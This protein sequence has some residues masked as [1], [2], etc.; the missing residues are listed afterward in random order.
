MADC[1]ID[2][3]VAVAVLAPSQATRALNAFAASPPARLIAPAAFGFE[4]RNAVVRLERRGLLI[5]CAVDAALEALE[6]DV[7]CEPA[8]DESEWRRILDIAR[9]ERLGAYDAAYLELALRTSAAV[10]SRDASL[11]AAALARGVR[12]HDLR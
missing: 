9:S 5:P 2:A 6:S 11:I 7:L 10:A 12:V 1:V 3:S 4:I 8:P